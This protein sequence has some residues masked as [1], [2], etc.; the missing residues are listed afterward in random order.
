MSRS[1]TV[2]ALLLLVVG[3]AVAAFY[4]Y[5]SGPEPGTAR[6]AQVGEEDRLARFVA[7]FDSL[8]DA[9][10]YP[11]VW[12]SGTFL[13]TSFDEDRTEWTLTI[14]SGDWGRRDEASKRDLAATLFSA[15]RGVRAQAGGDPEKAVLVIVDEDG[16]DLAESSEGSGTVILR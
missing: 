12:R 16:E 14:S 7:R 10:L 15:F 5:Y 4:F 11:T 3:L 8:T 6:I 9:R 1:A 2:I 13:K